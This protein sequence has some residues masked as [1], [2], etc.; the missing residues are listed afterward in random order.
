MLFDGSKGNKKRTPSI[1]NATTLIRNYLNIVYVPYFS[2]VSKFKIIKYRAVT[3]FHLNFLIEVNDA[4]LKT[5][6]FMIV[7]IAV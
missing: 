6:K 5:Q 7:V 3:D 1:F 4:V 2:K